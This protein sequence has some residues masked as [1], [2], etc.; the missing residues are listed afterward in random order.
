MIAK[1]V[2]KSRQTL[3][4]VTDFSCLTLKHNQMTYRLILLLLFATFL[5]KS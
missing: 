3:T 1:K 2:E 5:F 4:A